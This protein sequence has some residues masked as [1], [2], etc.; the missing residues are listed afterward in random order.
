MPSAD[1]VSLQLSR[2]ISAL[3]HGIACLQVYKHTQLTLM[4]A[5]ACAA[6][7]PAR[8]LYLLP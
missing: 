4:K 3:L 1:V 5:Q 2:I 6:Q 7:P 8:A